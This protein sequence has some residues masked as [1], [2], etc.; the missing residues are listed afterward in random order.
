MYLADD[1]FRKAG[2][3]ERAKVIFASAAGGIFAVQKY[4]KTLER[5]VARKGIETRF[6]HNLVEIRPEAKEAVFQRLDTAEQVVVPYEMI[7]VT[8]PM[9]AP[10]FLKHSPLANEAGGGYLKH[11]R[12][13]F[14][15]DVCLS[16][17]G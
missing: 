6:K 9:S 11:L 15:V 3:R 16:K 4:A 17:K 12:R 1:A 14:G 10:D 13:D 5:V 8:P 2:V 7:H